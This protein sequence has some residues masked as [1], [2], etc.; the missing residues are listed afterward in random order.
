MYARTC[1]GKAHAHVGVKRLKI[2]AC[3]HSCRNLVSQAQLGVTWCVYLIM[4]DSPF[5]FLFK[6]V[7]NV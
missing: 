3:K 4:Q 2:I 6:I 1:R 5:L 7:E